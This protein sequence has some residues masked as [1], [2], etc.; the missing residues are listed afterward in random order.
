MCLGTVLFLSMVCSY[1]RLQKTE[2]S[3]FFVVR[4]L[5]TGAYIIIVV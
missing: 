5:T 2:L 1:L 3:F 4:T